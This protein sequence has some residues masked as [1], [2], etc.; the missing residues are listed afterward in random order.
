M[1]YGG[2]GH[3][4][5]FRLFAKRIRDRSRLHFSREVLNTE[6]WFTRF[7]TLQIPTC[8]L[9]TNMMYWHMRLLYVLQT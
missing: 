2:L 9:P 4:T 3:R 6:P 7:K 1:T 5:I 8:K